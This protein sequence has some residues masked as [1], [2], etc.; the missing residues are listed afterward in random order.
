MNYSFLRPLL[1]K[2]ITVVAAGHKPLAVFEVRQRLTSPGIFLT[3]S[4]AAGTTKRPLNEQGV[5]HPLRCRPRECCLAHQ[6]GFRS[7]LQWLKLLRPS[8]PY[9]MTENWTRLLDFT[10]GIYILQN[11]ACISK[12]NIHIL[13]YHFMRILF[14]VLQNLSQGQDAQ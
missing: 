8:R 12:E 7:R 10:T 11:N 4:R 14:E 2:Q 9:F 3:R 6:P 5:R 1:D 13:L